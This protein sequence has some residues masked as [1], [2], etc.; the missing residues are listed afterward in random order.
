MNFVRSPI[1]GTEKTTEEARLRCLYAGVSSVFFL[2]LTLLNMP[3][4]HFAAYA[5]QTRV[6][7][8]RMGLSYLMPWA[9]EDDKGSKYGAIIGASDRMERQGSALEFLYSPGGQ[10]MDYRF[11]YFNRFLKPTLF[12]ETYDNV[13]DEFVDGVRFGRRKKGMSILGNWPLSRETN[14]SMGLLRESFSNRGSGPAILSQGSGTAI[15]LGAGFNRP[16]LGDNPLSLDLGTSLSLDLRLAGF[17]SDA[18]SYYQA[19]LRGYHYFKLSR[20]GS[21]FGWKFRAGTIEME[22]GSLYPDL[23]WLGGPET[24]RAFAGDQFYGNKSALLSLEYV[25]AIF[26]NRPTL[27][28][29]VHFDSLYMVFFGDAGDAWL[30]ERRGMELKKDLGVELRTTFHVM[31]RLPIIAT[32]GVARAF[33]YDDGI[34]IYFKTRGLF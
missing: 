12:F 1:R 19:D 15:L 26:R 4:L 17:G 28:Y 18:G 23:I 32:M 5:S 33:A 6:Y 29:P 24:L 30:Q 13:K 20:R 14:I 16:I 31:N 34:K 11:R 7:T 9:S 25:R 22:K 8:P 27:T 2:L 21:Y 10:K 3:F